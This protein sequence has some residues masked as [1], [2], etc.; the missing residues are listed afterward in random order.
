MLGI[1]TTYLVEKPVTISWRREKVVTE[2]KIKK[3]EKTKYVKDEDRDRSP[4]GDLL[5]LPYFHDITR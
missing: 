1:G 2:K 4:D 5:Y 3:K